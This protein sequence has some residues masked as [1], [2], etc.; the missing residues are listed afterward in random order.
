MQPDT[1]KRPGRGTGAQM[2][3]E[4]DANTSVTHAARERAELRK[5][6]RISLEALDRLIRQRPHELER[7]GSR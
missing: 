6:R 4:Q 1:K 2:T 5:R 3:A 7:G